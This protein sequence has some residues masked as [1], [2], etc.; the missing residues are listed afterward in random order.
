[1]AGNVILH[2]AS[3]VSGDIQ[4]VNSGTAVPPGTQTRIKHNDYI[5]ATFTLNTPQDVDT[6]DPSGQNYSEIQLSPNSGTGDLVYSI[7][8]Y[9]PIIYSGTDM[10]S[11]SPRNTF[12]R[13]SLTDATTNHVV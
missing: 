4:R 12:Y 2:N 5:N 7:A 8:A 11:S 10:T 13:V 6:V 3:G 9:A 1:M